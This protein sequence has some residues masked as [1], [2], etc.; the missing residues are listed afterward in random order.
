MAASLVAHSTSQRAGRMPSEG[1]FRSKTVEF[2]C[3]VLH[4]NVAPSSRYIYGREGEWSDED[5]RNV[6]R[7]ARSRMATKK[8][9]NLRWTLTTRAGEDASSWTL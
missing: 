5:L 7:M 3:S 9:K 2:V 4:R 8:T 1:G 6:S